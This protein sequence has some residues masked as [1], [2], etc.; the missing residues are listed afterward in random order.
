[1]TEIQLRN[2]TWG[3][4]G[5]K[6]T[7]QIQNALRGKGLFMRLAG[8]AREA[9]MDPYSAVGQQ[10]SLPAHLPGSRGDTQLPGDVFITSIPLLLSIRILNPVPCHQPLTGCILEKPP[11]DQLLESLQGRVPG[12]GNPSSWLEGLLI[13][14]CPMG[15]LLCSALS[16]LTTLTLHPPGCSPAAPSQQVSEGSSLIPNL[17]SEYTTRLL[18]EQHRPPVLLLQNYSSFPGSSTPNA[19]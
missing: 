13:P 17:E 19:A 12:R 2:D 3:R 5:R 8:S 15:W 11:C 1:M 10:W 7:E 16:A 14:S 4:R 18:L 9:T 6:S